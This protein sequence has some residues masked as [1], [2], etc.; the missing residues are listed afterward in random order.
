MGGVQLKLPVRTHECNGQVTAA[1]TKSLTDV[2]WQF[3]SHFSNGKF[4]IVFVTKSVDFVVVGGTSSSEQSKWGISNGKHV[5]AKSALCT[6]WLAF[7]AV[8][9]NI[10]SNDLN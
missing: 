4:A 10:P 9:G 6:F 8:L 1:H 7:I 2:R 3:S 5:I